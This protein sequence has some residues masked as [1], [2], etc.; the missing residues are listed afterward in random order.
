MEITKA[1]K[2]SDQYLIDWCDYVIG[3]LVKEKTDLVKAYNY[4][5][6]IRD[7]YQYEHLEKNFGI[8]NPTSV[9]FTP[10]TRK[11]IEA[12][13]GE[14]LSTKPQPKISC[15]DS[16][17]LTNIHRD[18]QLEISKKQKE[19]V[20]KYL[21]NAI[22]NA[23]AGNPQQQSPTKDQFIE[24]E[25]KNIT[26]SVQRGF[27]S[28][29]E[30]A[31]QDICEYVLQNRR[32]DF[33]NKLEQMLLDLL[34][35]GQTYYKVVPTHNRQNF[36]I[37]LCDPLNT[38]VDKDPKSRYMK[39]AYKSVVRKWMTIQEIEIKYGDWLTETDLKE[40]R[41][42]KSH[43]D[44]ND[45]SNYALITGLHSRCGGNPN[46]G[47]WDGVGVHPLDGDPSEE[48]WDLIPV[49]EVEWIDSKKENDKWIGYCYHVT[50]IGADIYVL[51]N[52]DVL[53]PRNADEPNI[54]RL[55][56]NGIWYTN[57]H[58]SPY[59][60]MLATADLQD[61]YDLTI[62]KKD[63]AIALAGTRG[64]IIDMAALPDSLGDTP[65]ERIMKFSGYRK[66]GL[67]LINTAQEGQLNMN[68]I[69]NGFDDTLQPGT[70][71][72]YQLSL[73]MIEETVSS[74][75]G[76]F[77][78]RLGGIE[79]R[80][81][82]A[83]VEVGMQQ[84]YIITKRYYQAMDTLVKEILTDCIDMAKVVYKEGMTGQ[85]ILGDQVKIFTLLPE[86][87]TFTSYDI[88]LAD[89]AEIIKEQE[90]I[91]QLAQGY[92]Q[93]NLMDPEILFIIYNSKSLT[94]M[95]ELAMRAIREKK[96]ENNQLQQLQ[97]QLEQ[98]QQQQQE[99][100]KQLEAST[101]KIAMLNEKKLN[102]EQQNNQ[103]DQELGYYKIEK[104][105]ELRNRELD[106]MEQKNKLEMAQ[107]FD[108][109]PN[110]DE[111]DNRRI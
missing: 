90:T 1:H 109:N 69:Y 17:T 21:E 65:E 47:L 3:D 51:D 39:D 23:I 35:A 20:S 79:Q 26:D 89:S 72:A 105:A 31:A 40:L 28:N 99:M 43:Y 14:Y 70:I 62:Y 38:W 57:G 52:D 84:S 76:V 2:G 9:G 73:Q 82:V 98:A 83:N 111:V 45:T 97:Q 107:L 56:I 55:T 101:K 5:N 104:D 108:S 85:I 66:I 93:S 67:S 36:K 18:K 81:A 11:H 37:E 44:Y 94:E 19:W 30:I 91:K 16:R 64:A 50:R 78:E 22:Y 96:I 32:I 103:M 59:S 53:M 10:L 15:K 34:I 41:S 13:V 100:Q 75:T 24:Q 86:Y 92:L 42:W 87:Y 7:H 88:S 80:D 71:Q 27:L 77:R 95:R 25:L 102:I 12:I 58:G 48:N 33:R 49:Y 8:G 46:P 63:N 106:I 54:P 6:G 60:L 4:F 61:R 68:T 29:Y 74:I 110:N